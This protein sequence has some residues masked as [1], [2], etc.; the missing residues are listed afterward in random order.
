MSSSSEETTMLL[1]EE[2]EEDVH[3][4]IMLPYCMLYHSSSISDNSSL[5]DMPSKRVNTVHAELEVSCH[6]ADGCLFLFSLGQAGDSQTEILLLLFFYL[7]H[8]SLSL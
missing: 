4:L 2:E 7:T 8:S 6:G 1:L 5:L 3:I